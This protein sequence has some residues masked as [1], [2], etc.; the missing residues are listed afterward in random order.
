[1][2]L[3]GLCAVK[4]VIII[5]RYMTTVYQQL[6]QKPRT[7]V[8]NPKKQRS[9]AYERIFVWAGIA[10]FA[11]AAPRVRPLFTLGLNR[12]ALFCQQG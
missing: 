6:L 7:T 5:P 4:T 3:I 1:M 10:F 2:Q 12:V 8:G 11:L 9:L